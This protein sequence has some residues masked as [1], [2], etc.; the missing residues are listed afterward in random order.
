LSR[1]LRFSVLIIISLLASNLLHAEERYRKFDHQK[2]DQLLSEPDYDY[3][4]K[5]ESSGSLMEVVGRAIEIFFEFLNSFYGLLLLLIL[6]PLVIIIAYRRRNRLKIKRKASIADFKLDPEV[7]RKELYN[8]LERLAEQAGAEEKFQ[9]GIRYYFLFVLKQLDIQ[10]LIRF[11][12]EKTNKHYLNELPKSMRK[13]FNRL[14][15]I[16]DYAWYGNYPVSLNLFLQVKKLS[17][18][19]ISLKDVA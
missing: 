2:L 8:D 19:L 13:D 11:H 3:E 7:N 14:S 4:K 17:K 1:K 10:K 9:L 6:L 16:F 18:Q 5:I 15:R 12:P